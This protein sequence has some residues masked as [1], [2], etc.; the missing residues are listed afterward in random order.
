ME[1]FYWFIRCQP[2]SHLAISTVNVGNRPATVQISLN[3]VDPGENTG[4]TN[5]C[6]IDHFSGIEDGKPFT[7]RNLPPFEEGAFYHPQVT[8]ATVYAMASAQEAI[9]HAWSVIYLF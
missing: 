1:F 9:T 6:G 7:D 2:D 4:G 5:A 3:R 8:S